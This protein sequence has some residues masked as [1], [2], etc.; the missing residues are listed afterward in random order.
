MYYEEGKYQCFEALCLQAPDPITPA[1]GPKQIRV[2]LLDSLAGFHINQLWKSKKQQ[3]RSDLSEKV[4]RLL[5]KAS[6]I[7]PNQSAT[8]IGRALIHLAR[9]EY[10]QALEEIQTAVVIQGSK[11]NICTFTVKANAYYSQQDY[12]RAL[13]YY[14]EALRADPAK[15]PPEIR[16]GM[17]QCYF[18]LGNISKA[19]QCFSR[20]IQLKESCVEAYIGLELAILNERETTKEKPGTY[21]NHALK[22][23]SK[24]P[25][26]F[27]YLSDDAFK[28]GNIKQSLQ[29]ADVAYRCA[30]S[31]SIQ[32]FSAF[33]VARAH[34]K[35]QQYG[36]AHKYYVDSNRL[37]NIDRQQRGIMI[38]ETVYG[39]SEIE[40][41]R[42]ESK[43]KKIRPHGR[44]DNDL[45][46][47]KDYHYC[48]MF[49]LGQS[50]LQRNDFKLAASCFERVI[51]HFSLHNAKE[52]G[53]ALASIKEMESDS[54]SLR[55]KLY[56]FS[57]ARIYREEQEK[58]NAEFIEKTRL[59][60]EAKE[61]GEK[62]GSRPQKRQIPISQDWRSPLEL[63]SQIEATQPFRAS[64]LLL[65]ALYFADKAWQHSIAKFKE[66][67]KAL[68][69]EL[70]AKKAAG[71]DESAMNRDDHGDDDEADEDVQR[72]LELEKDFRKNSPPFISMINNY[73]ALC[74]LV[75][76]W[77]DATQYFETALKTCTEILKHFD[78]I[79]LPESMS[80]RLQVEQIT[81]EYNA[82]LV[83]E[84]EGKIDKAINFLTE[85]RVIHPSYLR[86]LLRLA[87][88]HR[89]KGEREQAYKYAALAHRAH[90]RE[91]EPLVILALLRMD[92]SDF[93]GT[94]LILRQVLRIEYTNHARKWNSFAV[95]TLGMMEMKKGFHAI[96]T[97]I[98]E[99][100][101]LTLY[102][103][104][105]E[106][107]I[108]NALKIFQDVLKSNKTN[109]W[110]GEAVGVCLCML[111]KKEEGFRIISLVREAVNAGRGKT[112]NI[113]EA[114][115]SNASG[116]SEL[117]RV[118]EHTVGIIFELT[119]EDMLEDRMHLN[120]NIQRQ[121]FPEPTKF[122]NVPYTCP[123][124]YPLNF[125]PLFLHYNMACSSFELGNF[126]ETIPL[127]TLSI[128][129][130]NG[131][132]DLCAEM[133]LAECYAH[134]KD[135]TN[136]HDTFTSLIDEFPDKTLIKYNYGVTC[137]LRANSLV[138]GCFRD[139]KQTLSDFTKWQASKA[140]QPEPIDVEPSVL[141]DSDT[142]E[143]LD[144]LDHTL[145]TITLQTYRTVRTAIS[146]LETAKK[147]LLK[148]IDEF[149]QK[150]ST[151][152]SDDITSF[153]DILSLSQIGQTLASGSLRKGLSASTMANLSSAPAGQIVVL[154]L[155]E[156]RNRTQTVS[157]KS[158]DVLLANCNKYNDVAST[159]LGKR[160][161]IQM[162]ERIEREKEQER[163]K[164]EEEENQE[165]IKMEEMQRLREA[166]EAQEHVKEMAMKWRDK[167]EEF[168]M[169]KL[170]KKRK[171]RK[172]GDDSDMERKPPSESEQSY[173][174][175]SPKPVK[176]RKTKKR[177]RLT[178]KAENSS[179][180]SDD[181]AIFTGE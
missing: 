28:K 100:D 175:H 115:K 164:K 7:D 55:E 3:E 104:L 107:S 81:L 163:I 40:R 84:A 145:P 57:S 66:D 180:S 9:C 119:D 12:K 87:C 94:E 39:E 91:T 178:R 128:A 44:K 133:V 148:S 105:R 97:P 143:V 76:N 22:Y 127:L 32:S 61:K 89:L 68:Q 63:A 99:N 30:I 2:A 83:Y 154:F 18:K 114:I 150:I 23:S 69:E 130:L 138:L 131:R 95:L 93:E 92:E 27:N 157:L 168:K 116:Q 108:R 160:E 45:P 156:L 113:R 54:I 85:R 135:W 42:S 122:P 6:D 137:Y 136:M 13:H 126:I 140:D 132:R 19:K 43:G 71:G 75:G 153:E 73:A 36:E 152:F 172:G 17:G 176:K 142:K 90:P 58:A 170:T 98:Y 120:A 52:A 51:S 106:K 141:V 67:K 146:E 16:L 65:D 53:M 147:Q 123:Y 86:T 162:N 109:A 117:F 72:M 59:Y 20:C 26:I 118:H 125:P 129:R 121:S 31:S 5:S 110:A 4:N 165:R 173:V 64:Q 101:E 25:T 56:Y 37:Y 171:S 50:H 179:S 24:N 35:L 1:S 166:E 155:T 102:E 124:P 82:S 134:Q 139:I 149:D 29:L 112:S 144:S 34:H 158:I 47:E 15:A 177:K 161:T 8:W 10:N 41:I 14:S 169:R 70:A 74:A 48:V 174:E 49:G 78:P 80:A 38:E 77:K 33:L 151:G 62:V 103:T 88:L 167:E 11:D 159:V 96:P 181:A 21:L 60:E 46:G 79:D 111:G